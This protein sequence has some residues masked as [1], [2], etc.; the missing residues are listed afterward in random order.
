M[1]KNTIKIMI[2]IL[3]GSNPLQRS[4]IKIIRFMLFISK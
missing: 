2:K 1:N 3:E 4:S